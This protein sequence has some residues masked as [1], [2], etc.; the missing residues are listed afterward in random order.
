MIYMSSC[1][2]Y[3]KSQDEVVNEKS[4]VA[5]LYRVC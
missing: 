1:S 2:V 5:G 4:E 3:G